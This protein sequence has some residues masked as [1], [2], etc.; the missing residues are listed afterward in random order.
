MIPEAIRLLKTRRRFRLIRTQLMRVQAMRFFFLFFSLILGMTSVIPNGGVIADTVALDD[1][2]KY[3][4]AQVRPI[5][6]EHCVTCHGPEEQEGDLRLD[7]RGAFQRGGGSGQV[8][9]KDKPGS[10]RLLTSVQ[11][12][13]SDLQMPPDGKIPQEQIDVLQRW[14]LDGAYW[15]ADSPHGTSDPKPPSSQEL[16]DLHRAEHWSYLPI[17]DV[18]P[19]DL[20]QFPNLGSSTKASVPP[21]NAIDRFIGQKLNDHGIQANPPASRRTLIHRAY[22]NLIGLPPTFEQVEAFLADKRPNAFEIVIDQLLEN[23]HYGERWARHWLDIARYGDTTGYIA[24]SAETRYPYA[25]TFR[26]YVIEAFNSDKPFYQFIIEQI[27]ADQLQ[28]DGEDR[29]NLAAMGFLTVG[30]R[31]MNRQ[32]DIIDDQIDVIS[33]GFLG[34]SV[35]CSRCHDHKYDAI[36]TAD[37]Y[38]LYGVLAS[39]EAPPELPLINQDHDSPEYQ[40][41]LAARAGKQ[42][43]VDQWLEERRVK[44]ELEL[45][46]R[47][48]DYLVYIARSLPKYSNGEK[49]PMQGERGPLRRAAVQRWQAY[50]TQPEISSEPIWH[51][52][53]YLNSLPVEK[54]KSVLQIIT[55]GGEALAEFT[56]ITEEQKLL[57]HELP[58]QLL[59]DLAKRRPANFPEASKTFGDYLESVLKRWRDGKQ[60]NP[61]LAA[62]PNPANEAIRKILLSGRTPAT[63]D[64]QQAI[65]HLDQ[66]E[67][68]RFNQLKNT[69]NSVAITHPG[70]PPRAMIL[71]DRANPIEPVIFRRGVPGNRGDKVPRRFLQILEMVD[72][73]KPFKNGSGRLELAQ[74]IASN[75]NPL[76][77]RVIV[78]RIWQHQFGQ[79][80]VR[81]PSDFGI[82]GEKPTH[83]DLLDHLASQFMEEGWSIKKL[84]KRILLSQT[85]QQSSLH[86]EDAF[87]KDP[88]N[89]LLWKSQRR[90]LEFEPLRDRLL[91]ASQKLDL[92]I[93]GRSVKIHEDA[94]RRAIYA[95][96]DRED[97]PGLLANFDLPSPDASR[98]QRSETTVPQQAL[99]LMNSPFV[100]D[101]ARTLATIS[102]T[103][104]TQESSQRE[105]ATRVRKM[106]QLA[107]SRNPQDDELALAL[108]FT[109]PEIIESFRQTAQDQPG[110]APRPAWSSG[111]GGWSDGKFSFTPFPHFTGDAWQFSGEFPHPKFGY[112]RLTKNGGHTGASLTLSPIRKWTAPVAGT[113][114]ISG[115]LKHP[116]DQGDGVIGQV[117]A[118]EKGVLKEWKIMNGEIETTHSGLTLEK[119]D[120]L[121][122][123]VHFNEN[124]G[125]DSFTWNP[126]IDLVAAT[127]EEPWQGPNSWEAATEF[128]ASSNHQKDMNNTNPIDPWTQL[129]QALLLSNEFAFVD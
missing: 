3:F 65:A 49:I 18:T 95:Y 44:T 66:G 129:A 117:I 5:L 30:R 67:R 124:T 21:A 92:D 60:A 119:G 6:V 8:I 70:A 93:G 74:A 91:T 116:S 90:R 118:A 14:I 62:L 96:I 100:L 73:G 31:F 7:H 105:R 120:S 43:E 11:Y 52:L 37:Y 86:R 99:Y 12:D 42:S 114:Q 121:Y 109:N 50:L 84:Q 110:F 75:T 78:N 19:P 102:H 32:V 59:Q 127:G 123:A 87:A 85:W 53:R 13:D 9:N 112:L 45:Q 122:L 80:L 104:S 69:V 27:A 107:L 76:T 79:G 16:I 48:A 106:Y 88:E 2:E 55:S 28:L 56:E 82:R 33:R 72:Q 126:I 128:L 41:F 40:K 23:P 15:P 98:A 94:N 1:R 63:L 77:A 64:T 22:F 81:T 113:Y 25:Y 46:E 97:L 24:G 108:D 89:R 36:P 4:E 68:N 57:V 29:S 26:D 83:P 38:S 58:K 20:E 103:Q 39:S 17:Q 35:A 111:Y 71:R 51:F 101:Q 34:L 47:I 10:S 61:D 115:Q 125:W 54:F